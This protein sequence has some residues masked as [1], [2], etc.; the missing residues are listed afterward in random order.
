M[1]TLTDKFGSFEEQIASEH[2]A[3]M[4]ALTSL[5]ASIDAVAT[6]TDLALVN[7]AVNTRA[8]LAALGQTGACFPCPT[9][10]IVVPPVSTT[11]T[12]IDDDHCKRAQWLVATIGSLLSNIDTLQSYNVVATFSVLNDAITEI[13]G[14]IA[15]GDTIPLP[16][17]PEVVQLVGTYFNMVAARAFSGETIMAQYGPLQSSL[18]SAVYGAADA[19]AAKT[20]YDA[21]IDGSSGSGAFK[22]IA[23]AVAY[24]ALFTYALDPATMP[25]LS[26]FDGGVCTI[27]SGTC[28]TLTL[29]PMTL[30][31]GTHDVGVDVAFG[32]FNPT[33]TI[34]QGSGAVTSVPPIFF[35]GSLDG[36]VYETVS[37][38]LGINYRAT[39]L[40]TP[41]TGHADGLPSTSGTPLPFPTGIGSFFFGGSEGGVFRVCK[42]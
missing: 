33:D 29:V 23:K 18:I 17:F 24:N 42:T 7:G 4:D 40:S 30:S 37:G 3:I 2:T 41:S 12:P 27:P 10:S 31:N 35:N 15:A 26:A 39:D 14:A 8:L 25:D 21:V 9:P 22:Q 36:W 6:N 1:T 19:A 34:I 13:I 11:G 5:A 20:A 38:S 28:Y 16:S 32:P